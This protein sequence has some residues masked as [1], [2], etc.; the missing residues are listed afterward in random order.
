MPRFVYDCPDGE[1]IDVFGEGLMRAL[2]SDGMLNM[3][4]LLKQLSSVRSNRGEN[5]ILKAVTSGAFQDQQLALETH[6]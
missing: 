3:T 4:M 1:M 2:A 5:A 6:V